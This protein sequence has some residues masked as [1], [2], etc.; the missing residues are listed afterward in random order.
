MS[1]RIILKWKNQKYVGVLIRSTSRGK[2]QS[3]WEISRWG[4]STKDNMTYCLSVGEIFIIKAEIPTIGKAKEM[5]QNL[6]DVLDG[7]IF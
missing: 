5:A 3:T 4:G 2:G 1:E 7:Y 6:Q